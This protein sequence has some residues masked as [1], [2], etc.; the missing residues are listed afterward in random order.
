M[1]ALISTIGVSPFSSS[2]DTWAGRS[3]WAVS[4]LELAVTGARNGGGGTAGAV[5]IKTSPG[6]S[7]T[8]NWRGSSSTSSASGTFAVLRLSR[9][10][11]RLGR[12]FGDSCGAPGDALRSEASATA[13]CAG[14]GTLTDILS[15]R[16]L[17]SRRFFVF[18][19]SGISC[20]PPPSSLEASRDGCT[21]LPA[22]ITSTLSPSPSSAS[23]STRFRF[24]PDLR[25]FLLLFFR[26]LDVWLSALSSG[27]GISSTSPGSTSYTVLFA[28]VA[29][30]DSLRVG[31]GPSESRIMISRPSDAVKSMISFSSIIQ[32][33]R[34]E[35]EW[36]DKAI[37]QALGS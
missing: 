2:T 31:D 12:F 20:S 18:F 21:E 13:S 35:V 1:G 36:F 8:K 28:C 32:Y 15:K 30:V 29:R 3:S 25:T 37:I 27:L 22:V 9:V 6:L 34:M 17:P 14:D 10:F 19:V 23:T 26:L 24:F 11:S 33:G 16:L 5:T 4:V 7:S